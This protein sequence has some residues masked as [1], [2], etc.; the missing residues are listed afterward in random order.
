MQT[1]KLRVRAIVL[2]FA[3]FTLAGIIFRQG[4]RFGGSTAATPV[5][6]AASNQ[7]IDRH[8]VARHALA[9]GARQP[10][11]WPATPE[12]LLREFWAALGRADLQ[13]VMVLNP[14]SVPADY[15]PYQELAGGFQTLK[16]IEAD[17][18]AEATEDRH[19]YIVTVDFARVR[20]KQLH[21]VVRRAEDGRYIIDGR[22]TQWW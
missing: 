12:A 13:R 4:H 6:H 7:E 22:A 2:V 3:L 9:A 21:M 10:G 20:A 14:G 18:A 19:N 16:S 5:A 11:D 1:F 8:A 15:N 17:P